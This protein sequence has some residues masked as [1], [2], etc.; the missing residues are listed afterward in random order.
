M[1]TTEPSLEGRHEGSGRVVS[2][3]P[4]LIIHVLAPTLEQHTVRAFR[5]AGA[6][7]AAA[8]VLEPGVAAFV[9]YHDRFPSL[10][11][12]ARVADCE[13]DRRFRLVGHGLHAKAG[14]LGGLDDADALA[15][16]ADADQVPLRPG[17]AG[18]R[19][20]PDGRVAGLVPALAVTPGKGSAGRCTA[21]PGPCHAE[22]CRSRLMKLLPG[23]VPA[24]DIRLGSEAVVARGHGELALA[25]R[26]GPGDLVGDVGPIELD[27]HSRHAGRGIDGDHRLRGQPDNVTVLRTLQGIRGARGKPISHS[28]RQN[29]YSSIPEIHGSPPDVEGAAWSPLLI[30]GW[31]KKVP[32]GIGRGK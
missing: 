32:V 1:T 3:P 26:G 20:K 4:E 12:L 5:Q 14:V 17:R 6:A 16:P 21:R 28:H 9:G 31:I 27:R 13:T 18:V 11:L 24:G 15:N 22:V 30:D 8:H 2:D 25:W 10:Y 7:R 19:G 23:A 29:Q